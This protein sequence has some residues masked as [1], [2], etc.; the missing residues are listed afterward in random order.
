MKSKLF[1]ELKHKFSID[2]LKKQKVRIVNVNDEIFQ[3][4]E[5]LRI[6]R[7]TNADSQNLE[8]TLGAI[9]YN[10]TV[11]WGASLYKYS[12]KLSWKK[13]SDIASNY[14]DIIT[15]I[16]EKL[17]TSS[18]ASV[19]M[20]SILQSNIIDDEDEKI[21]LA[22]DSALYY[23]CNHAVEYNGTIPIVQKRIRYDYNIPDIEKILKYIKVFRQN[24]ID[25][26]REKGGG[27]IYEIPKALASEF[28]PL[29]MYLHKYLM[30][31][32]ENRKVIYNICK[33]VEEYDEIFKDKENKEEV[34]EKNGIETSN[35]GI[36][37]IF[38]RKKKDNKKGK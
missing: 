14:R 5:S 2:N 11:C 29:L 37:K 35:K 25:S 24:K 1:N 26:F 3:H 21:R 28:E 31:K 30:L 10:S 36:S 6:D 16:R 32:D 18:K 15:P 38:R 23:M 22:L 19:L 33:G 7:L 4:N 8:H 17:N 20:A 12:D 13:I 27:S 9:I 34:K